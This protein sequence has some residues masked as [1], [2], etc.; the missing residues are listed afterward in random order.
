MIWKSEMK[1]RV[2]YASDRNEHVTSIMALA[3]LTVH[4]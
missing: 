2:D 1:S 4:N 3:S